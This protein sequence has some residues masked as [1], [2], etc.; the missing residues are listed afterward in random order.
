MNWEIINVPFACTVVT[1][2]NPLQS[3]FDC[4]SKVR[5]FFST[6][7][8]TYF[9][10]AASLKAHRHNFPSFTIHHQV[11]RCEKLQGML[12]TNIRFAYFTPPT[13]AS[14]WEKNGKYL[15]SVCSPCHYVNKGL[16]CLYMY[17]NV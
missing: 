12:H 13:C 11:L 16:I 8:L 4:Q 1:T 7:F 15:A 3:L 2:P 17:L 14:C 6:S 10:P 5:L 9:P